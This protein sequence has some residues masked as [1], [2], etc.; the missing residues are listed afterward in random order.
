MKW[1]KNEIDFLNK[2]Y[3][4]YGSEYC[5]EKLNTTRKRITG[6]TT[7]LGLKTKVKIYREHKKSKTINFKLFD[8]KFTKESVYILGLL[9]ADGTQNKNQKYMSINC[10]ETDINEVIPIFNCTGEWIISEPIIKIFN[11]KR[12]KTQ[13][14]ISTSSWGLYEILENYGYKTKSNMSP[15]YM[16]SKIPNNLKKYWFRGYLDGDGCIRL[17]KKYGVSVVFAG[18]YEQNW[19]FMENLCNEININ[20]RIDKCLV[21]IGGYS[22]FSIDRKNDV[23][24]LCDYLYNEYDHIGF[25]RKYQK[26]LD[27]L[28]YIENKSKR[29]WTDEDTKWLINNYNLI[30]GPE[31]SKILK[32]PLYSIYNK[33]VQLKKRK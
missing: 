5:A 27:V 33:I 18:S 6:K 13:K 21:K 9:W 16:L 1:T 30:S 22:H 8:D 3:E 25:S 7:Q 28:K 4:K 2:N 20:F 19:L 23:K 15:D 32:K 17:G 24:I 26:Y 14:K 12:V 10:C 31:C 29:F 11:G